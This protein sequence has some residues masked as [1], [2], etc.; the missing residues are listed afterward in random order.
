MLKY[1]N[2]FKKKCNNS[3]KSILFQYSKNN[4]TELLT[5]TPV[6]HNEHDPEMVFRVTI[7]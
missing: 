6:L 2:C 7:L 1:T 3:H 4:I 5:E